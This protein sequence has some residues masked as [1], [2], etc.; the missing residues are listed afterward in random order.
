M[1]T[2][3]KRPPWEKKEGTFVHGITYKKYGQVIL[4]PKQVYEQIKSLLNESQYRKTVTENEV[5]FDFVG[6]KDN[7]KGGSQ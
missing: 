4:I 7:P 2:T 6:V 5:R 1:A 3:K